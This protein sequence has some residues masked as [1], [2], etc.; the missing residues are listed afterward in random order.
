[1]AAVNYAVLRLAGSIQ[2]VFDMGRPV[3][4]R[5]SAD[6]G[7]GG[8]PKLWPVRVPQAREN[9]GQLESTLYNGDS[10]T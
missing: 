1:M 8:Q 5:C 6:A 4:E 9:E 2:V 3:K 10:T 7:G